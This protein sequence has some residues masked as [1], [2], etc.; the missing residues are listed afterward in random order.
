MSSALP[1]LP[2]LVNVCV[3]IR[4]DG[5]QRGLVVQPA[6][7]LV[8]QQQRPGE[9][10]RLLLRNE[11]RLVEGELRVDEIDIPLVEEPR[12]DENEFRA[13]VQRLC[14]E[15]QEGCRREQQP[16]CAEPEPFPLDP[17]DLLAAHGL[18]LV[19]QPRHPGLDG[20]DSDMPELLDITL[21]VPSSGPARCTVVVPFGASGRPAGRRGRQ[22]NRLDR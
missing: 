4:Y 5:I 10:R 14:R 16:S 8:E 3:T 12:P 13:L 15:Q 18:R 1:G 19:E 9:Q 17:N 6:L 21:D 2:M 7:L 11:R 20:G 22:S